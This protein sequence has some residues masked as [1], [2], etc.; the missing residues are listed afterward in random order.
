MARSTAF[1]LTDMFAT[2][3]EADTPNVTLV[4]HA[5]I[6]DRLRDIVPPHKSK[7]SLSETPVDDFADASNTARRST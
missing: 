4:M 5:I 1:C 2:N 3:D 7:V 6:P